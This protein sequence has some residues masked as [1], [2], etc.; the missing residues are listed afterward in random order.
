M[1]K[2]LA[3]LLTMSMVLSLVTVPVF[4]VVEQQ[5]TLTEYWTKAVAQD[6]FDEATPN[7]THSSTDEN[8]S[9]QIAK[10]TKLESNNR[11]FYGIGLHDVGAW[12]KEQ[13]FYN[14]A[15]GNSYV[16]KGTISNR[17]KWARNKP[18]ILYFNADSKDKDSV[19]YRAE[20]KK[21]SLAESGNM[22]GATDDDGGVEVKFYKGDTQLGETV[23][24]KFFIG[25]ATSE[26]GAMYCDF[27]ATFTMNN[28]GLSMAMSLTNINTN[29]KASGQVINASFTDKDPIKAGYFGFW[30]NGTS[31]VLLGNFEFD[32]S[33]DADA[34]ATFNLSEGV[35]ELGQKY[36]IE[37]SNSVSN[38]SACEDAIKIYDGEDLVSDANVDD[39]LYDSDTNKLEF[40]VSNIEKYK[41]YTLKLEGLYDMYGTMMDIETEFVPIQ[42]LH[43]FG[44]P[45]VNGFSSYDLSQLSGG[46]ANLETTVYNKDTEGALDKYAVTLAIIDENGK[47]VWSKAVENIN[48]AAGD[49]ERIVAENV[50][51]PEDLG[52]ASKV[53]AFLWNSFDTENAGMQTIYPDNKITAEGMVEP[54]NVGEVGGTV[55]VSGKVP[56]NAAGKRVTVLMLNK[57]K[58]VADITSGENVIVYQGQTMSG[59]NGDYTFTFP[60]NPMGG[61]GDYT[62]YVS[63]QNFT[64][65]VSKTIYYV[66][67][68][69]KNDAVKDINTATTEPDDEEKTLADYIVKHERTLGYSEDA[70]YKTLKDCNAISDIEKYILLDKATAPYDETDA[71]ADFK[72]RFNKLLLL[73]AYKHNLPSYVYDGDDIELINADSVYYTTLYEGDMT[74]DGRTAVRNAIINKEYV[75][76]EDTVLTNAYTALEESFI[77]SVIINAVFYGID[78]EEENYSYVTDII[79]TYTTADLEIYNTL[80]EMGQLEVNE[81]LAKDSS[82]TTIAEMETRFAEIVADYEYEHRLDDNTKYSYTFTEADLTESAWTIGEAYT[83]GT[84]DDHTGL[85][86]SAGG[87]EEPY[88]IVSPMSLDGDY[89][90]TVSVY[91]RM[92]SSYLIF[93]KSDANNYYKLLNAKEQET[94]GSGGTKDVRYATLTSVEDGNERQI[95]KVKMPAGTDY[96][97]YTF[98]LKYDSLGII[99]INMTKNGTEYPIIIDA[100]DTTHRSGKFAIALNS[101]VGI[102]KSF[103]YDLFLS[104]TG[105]HVATGERVGL[106]EAAEV[107]FNFPIDPDCVEGNFEIKDEQGNIITDYTYEIADVNRTLKIHPKTK[108]KEDSTY[109]FVLKPSLYMYMS[110]KGAPSE[111]EYIFRTESLGV[112]AEAPVSDGT[113]VTINIGNNSDTSQ[114][115]TAILTVTD[116]S[117]NQTAYED[118]VNVVA[119]TTTPATA[120]FTGVGDVSG[121]TMDYVLLNDNMQTVYPVVKNQGTATLTG[122]SQSKNTGANIEQ[123]VENGERVLYISGTTE[124]KL[125][126]RNINIVVEDNGGAVVYANR[127]TTGANGTFESQIPVNKAETDYTISVGG[128]DYA[129]PLSDTHKFATNDTAQIA[130]EAI[131]RNTTVDTIT[132][133][134]VNLGINETLYNDSRINKDKLATRVSNRI[135]ALSATRARTIHPLA[136]DGGA[137]L[138]SLINEQMLFMAYESNAKD[139][140]FNHDGSFKTDI[141]DMADVDSALTAKVWTPYTKLNATGKTNVD[142]SLFGKNYTNKDQL[143]TQFVAGVVING[144]Q[145]YSIN[146]Y[147]HIN[148]LIKDNDVVNLSGTDTTLL[149]IPKYNGLTNTGS[150]DEDLLSADLST[151]DTLAELASTIE[152]LV[153]KGGGSGEGLG[154][155][156]GSGSGSGGGSG[157]G[158]GSSEIVEGGGG[159]TVDN[160][161]I[162][163]TVFN[164]IAGVEWA[165]EAIEKLYYKAVL[166]GDGNGNFRPNDS[167]LREEFVKIAVEAF[168]MGLGGGNAGFTDCSKDD[169]CYQY[170]NTAK[171]KKIITGRADGSFGMGENITREDVA[172]IL[173]RILVANKQTDEFTSVIDSFTD[174][175]SISDYAYEA[176]DYLTGIGVIN[177]KGNGILQPRATCT[178][179]EAAKMVYEIIK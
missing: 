158:G 44:E 135:S 22:T 161:T 74:A 142:N 73:L 71:G 133:N 30:L 57:A 62:V 25:T 167:V 84:V 86:L 112:Y 17:A 1:K 28:D 125:K 141:V 127:V 162:Q 45:K 78:K 8:S 128:D 14:R 89:E 110:D 70:L 173:Y 139:L 20:I 140:I 56:G 5:E 117:G 59:V 113:D 46:T 130:A 152:G 64:K 24:Q 6:K 159:P 119:N 61:P 164:D 15:F 129:T 174:K 111:K 75:K 66:T 51:I 103:K 58:T 87:T 29:E 92:N 11:N 121:K 144:I 23:T 118:T 105:G 12:S 166:S 147:G 3:V 171:A 155:G 80:P 19:A 32:Y 168:D 177:G 63:G 16:V 4:A 2:F 157:D 137:G 99:S 145:N 83:W 55:T 178:R 31:Q 98:T 79:K 85:Y 153:P 150:V 97:A 36:Q 134:R 163:K 170:L 42:S 40:S 172:V 82:Y 21:I 54:T 65:P 175:D 7:W 81:R 100:K 176:I 148:S 93:N 132:A 154:G 169:W 115:I 26:F 52:S 151:V 149:T 156:A 109:T 107:G 88:E 47:M 33:C 120:T 50:T 165:K 146:G 18:V 108:W 10:T 41:E 179:A 53:V 35:V 138:Q 67:D 95:A 43:T 76:A 123:R 27:V 101:T 69:D 102:V 38:T 77:Q 126:D 90:L 37:F 60:I 106:T 116:A 104:A 68:G 13:F 72:V 39:V 9:Y 131:I 94:D 91:Q 48:L 124:S 122:T 49:D 114:N 96:S 143:Y 136:A 160:S 34:A